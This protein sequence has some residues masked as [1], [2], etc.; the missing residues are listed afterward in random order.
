[1]TR[2]SSSFSMVEIASD[3]FLAMHVFLILRSPC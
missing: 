3:S 2:L 1:V